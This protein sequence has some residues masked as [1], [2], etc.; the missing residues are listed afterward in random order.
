VVRVR[1]RTRLPSRPDPGR[2]R[3]FRAEAHDRFWW[4]KLAATDYVPAL[5]GCLA[6]DEWGVMEGWFAETSRSGRIAEINVP[7]MALMTGLVSGNGV[8]RVVQLGHYYGYSALLLGF[9]MRRMGLASPGLFTVDIDA[10]ATAFTRRWVERAGLDGVVSVVEG[11]S[12]DAGMPAQARESLGGAPEVV[13]VDSSHAY[14]HTLAELD[15]WA[16]E[17]PPGALILLHDAS[18]FA[19]QFDPTGCGGVHRA[20]GEWLARS[21]DW[22]G[23]TLNGSVAPGADGDALVYKDACGLGILQRT[24]TPPDPGSSSPPPG[25]TRSTADAT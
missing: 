23:M 5:Y 15:L 6:Q 18:V 20:I 13:L 24:F 11:D 7:A 4:H 25:D 19:Q 16:A 12:A 22:T 1:R 10:A 8:R 21:P 3:R 14:E 2:S 9:A 17:M